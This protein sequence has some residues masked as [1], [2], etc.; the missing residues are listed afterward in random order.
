VFWKKMDPILYYIFT[1][2]LGSAF[3]SFFNVLIWR[4]PRGESIVFP[5][6]YC[7]SCKT[8]IKFIYNIPLLGFFLTG[9]KCAHCKTAISL[10]YPCIELFTALCALLIGYI[11]L[12]KVEEI[13]ILTIIPVIVKFFWLLLMIPMSI[14]DIKKYII[15]DQ[16]TLPFIIAG[17]VLSFLP[18]DITPIN[19]FLGIVAGGGSL[20]LIGILGSW[21]LKKEEVM[22]GGD[23]KLMA[24]FGALFG[25]QLTLLSIMLGACLG[26]LSGIGMMFSKKIQIDHKIPF[27]PFLACGIWISF[28]FGERI[29]NWYISL[30]MT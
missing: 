19:S 22:G 17:L 4:I 27:G 24:A 11:F 16:F 13:S 28:L 6:S 21:I 30:L 29:I 26:S 8:P 2:L 7:P 20:L 10:I 5:S 12:S 15:P 9:G 25:W 3:G 1:F 18:F 23:I 14:I